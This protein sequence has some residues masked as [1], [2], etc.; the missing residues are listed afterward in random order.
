VAPI[1]DGWEAED[2]GS[3][4]GTLFNDRPLTRA[5]LRDGDRLQVGRSVLRFDDADAP[6]LLAEVDAET[7]VIAAEAA[8]GEAGAGELPA[9]SRSP[10]A[11]LA[12]GDEGQLLTGLCTWLRVKTGAAPAGRF[13]EDLYYRLSVLAPSSRRCASAARA[14]RPS[15]GISSPGWPARSAGSTAS[16]RPPSTR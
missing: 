1:T 16:R 11:V 14:S 7:T 15:P 3:R 12:A 10:D 8:S 9:C 5:R 13:R 6:P 2:I 4:N